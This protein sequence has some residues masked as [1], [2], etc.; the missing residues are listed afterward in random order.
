[1]AMKTLL[2]LFITLGLSVIVS[3]S[4]AQ[5]NK[6]D[7]G[8][9]TGIFVPSNWMIQ[10]YH[11]VEYVDGSPEDIT[12]MGFGNGVI[13]NLYTK[14]YFTDNLGIMLEV[15]ADLLQKNKLELALAPNG[16][17]D[18][19]ENSLVIF[20]V[21]LSLIHR[22]KLTETKFSPFTGVGFGVYIS[23]WE[24]EHF[25][26]R[27]SRRWFQGSEN[28]IG[29]KFFTGFDLP[30]Y[31]NLIFNFQFDYNYAATD[32]T[33]TDTDSDRET[34]YNKLNIGGVSLKLGI[35]FKF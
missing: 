7:V 2:K 18:M 30:I 12:M 35:G 17:Y 24:Q 20:P 22:L 27:G 1:M 15:G 3:F 21:N 6:Y 33:I 4:F 16:E 29:I 19:Y 11:Y 31:H 23:Q 28:P 32:W 13:L 14:Y 8:L 34:V 26:G 25:P 5:D 10:G 9:R